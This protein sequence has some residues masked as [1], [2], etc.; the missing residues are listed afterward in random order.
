MESIRRIFFVAQ[1]DPANLKF[2]TTYLHTLSDINSL[3]NLWYILD[4]P[5]AQ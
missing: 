1:I 5:P 3:A 4:P 2:Q